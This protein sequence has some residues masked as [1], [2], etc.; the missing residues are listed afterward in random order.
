MEYEQIPIF[1]SFGLIER[2]VTALCHP[3]SSH[4]MHLATHTALGEIPKISQ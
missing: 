3:Q 4:H 2:I 1:D